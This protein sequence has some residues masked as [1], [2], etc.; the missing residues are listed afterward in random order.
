MYE[1]LRFEKQ[2]LSNAIVMMTNSTCDF[3]YLHDPEWLTV[4]NCASSRYLFVV[5]LLCRLELLR[6]KK[7]FSYEALVQISFSVQYLSFDT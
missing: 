3:L 6:I 4:P 5:L 7:R 2:L 1:L